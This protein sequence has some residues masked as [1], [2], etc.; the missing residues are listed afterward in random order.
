ML[1]KDMGDL[2][3]RSAHLLASRWRRARQAI[4][5]A[6]HLA[7]HFRRDALVAR[8]GSG[9]GV[10]QEDLDHA[11]VR[12]C[13]QQV[14]C[15][16]VAQQMWRDLLSQGRRSACFLANCADR[17]WRDRSVAFAPRREQPRARMADLPVAAQ[18]SQQRRRKRHVAILATLA[19]I[20]VDR[21]T[22][23][24]DVG[25]FQP[26]DFR[27]AQTRRIDSTQEGSVLVVAHGAKKSV[28]LLDARDHGKFPGS[29]CGQNAPDFPVAAERH[30][31]E[32][33]QG[34]DLR[35]KVTGRDAL[36][37]DQVDLPNA[38]FFLA[39]QVG[40]LAEVL[41]ESGDI[42]DVRFLC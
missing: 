41:R 17:L 12:P 24:V 32:K 5:Q 16:C 18:K 11:R 26:R 10:A 37:L 2:Q 1:A 13:L 29:F 28:H 38:D 23:A 30:A 22:F 31:V 33:P 40:R 8:G 36:L 15:A 35:V 25:D 6:W 27:D 21:H 34:A 9:T 20:D 14:S 42:G 19:L 7:D 3:A 4:Q 39:Q